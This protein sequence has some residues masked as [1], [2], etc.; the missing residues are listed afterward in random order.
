MTTVAEGMLTFE[1]AWKDNEPDVRLLLAAGIDD[2]LELAQAIAG[3]F[4]GHGVRAGYEQGAHDKPH[5]HAKT[6][7]ERA[8]F[9]TDLAMDAD[10][11]T[12]D[13]RR[14]AEEIVA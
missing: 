2:R 6:V 12:A 5:R 1:K 13:Q 11:L 9:V 7:G 3:R 14:W 10:H 8:S 4:F